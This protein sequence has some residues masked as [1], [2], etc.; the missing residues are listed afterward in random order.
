MI[1][2][3]GEVRPL[4]HKGKLIKEGFVDERLRGCTYEFTVGRI[5]YRYDYQER[6]SRQENQESHIVYSSAT[7]SIS[8]RASLGNAATPI[9]ERA[10][11]AFV[12]KCP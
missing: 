2:T 3:D 11:G 8:T 12:K 9:V 6:L 10:G 7:T 1:M 4:C 5:A